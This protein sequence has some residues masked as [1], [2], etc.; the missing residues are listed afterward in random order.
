MTL[1]LKLG[2]A[3]GALELKTFVREREA[4]VFSFGLPIVL[5]LIFGTIF[6]GEVGDT[7]VDFRQYFAA[8]IIA[9]GIMSTTFISLGISIANERDDGTL[10]RLYGTPMPRASYFIGKTVSALVLSVA[11][12]AVLFAVGGALLGLEPPATP[13]RWFTFGWVFVL[14]VAA[15]TLLGIAVSS[16]PRSGR[17]AA[18]VLNLPYLVLQF[19]SGVFFVF[20]D[21]PSGVQ[22]VGA[23]FPLKWMCQGLRSALLPDVLLAAEPARSWE[24]GRIALVLAAWCIGG[25][26]LCLTT[27]RWKRRHER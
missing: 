24:H 5:L 12:T 18:A 3:R 21:L 13:Q 2:L 25:L 15:C 9:G 16:V 11:E 1:A 17:S 8:G 10:K 27:F 6:E 4:V 7:G 26:V 19:I 14:G 22:Q 23:L 20:G